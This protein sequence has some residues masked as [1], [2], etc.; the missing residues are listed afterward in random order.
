MRLDF[1]SQT[2]YNRVANEN[3]GVH[4]YHQE[5]Q[6]NPYGTVHTEGVFCSLGVSACRPWTVHQATCKCNELPHLLRRTAQTKALYS[7]ISPPPPFYGVG[8]P[9]STEYHKFR[10]FAMDPICQKS[11][12]A[13]AQRLLLS[14]D[15]LFCVLDGTALADDIDLDLAGVI[16]RVLDLLC[17]SP[18]WCGGSSSCLDFLR[19]WRRK[20]SLGHTTD[21]DRR[22]LFWSFASRFP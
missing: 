16:Q 4:S 1:S 12:C 22:C 2:A 20:S 13:Y 7:F 5:Q 6:E 10:H 8:W 17:R 11:R 14:S 3:N 19:W 18:F 21:D 9:T 15:I